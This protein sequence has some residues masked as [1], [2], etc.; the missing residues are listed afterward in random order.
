MDAELSLLHILLYYKT[1]NSYLIIK[2]Y[3]YSFLP[4]L[5]FF[6]FSQLS[7]L[8]SSIIFGKYNLLYNYFQCTKNT[9]YYQFLFAFFCSIFPAKYP[10]FHSYYHY[11][12]QIP[13]PLPFFPLFPSFYALFSFLSLF[14]LFFFFFDFFQYPD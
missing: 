7:T 4:S 12:C 2:Q 6:H 10:S 11:C 9:T 5:Q 1:I 14:F 3:K 8:P 13:W